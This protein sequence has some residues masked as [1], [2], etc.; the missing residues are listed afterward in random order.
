VGAFVK[1]VSFFCLFFVSG[2]ML[3]ASSHIGNVKGYT[4]NNAGELIHFSNMVFDAGKVVA[5]GAEELRQKY[6]NATFID[7]EN[8]VLLPGLIDAHG[9]VMGLGETLLQV[10][11]RESKSALDAAKMVQAYA[12][13]QQDLPWV[14]GRGWNQ[15]L[16]PGKAYPTASLLDE[17]VNNK[18]VMLSRV[19]GHASWVNTKALEIAGITKDTLDPPGGKIVRDEQGNP[20]GV[21]IDNAESLMLKHL[22]KT[23]EATLTAQLNAAG[24]HLLSEGITSVHDAGIGKVVYNYYKKRVAEHSLPVRIYPMIAATSADLRQLLETGHVQDQYDWLSIRSVKAYGDGAL[25]SRGAALLQP[26]S[27]A[28]DNTGLLVTREQDLKPLFDLVLGQGFQLN[29][30]AIGDRANRL[31]LDQ[32]GDSFERMGG[33]SLRNRV[34]H[35]QVV[36]VD[37]IPRFKALNIIPAMQPTHATSDM[38]MAKDRVGAAR[39]KGAY[40][41]Q[42]F[43]EQGSPVAF[44]SDFPVELSN[45]FFGLHAAV[46]RQD[47]NNSP[48]S[49]WIPS[50]AVTLKQAFRGFTLDAAYA[51]HQEKILGGLTQGKWADFILIDQDVFT[52]SPQNI[53]KTQVLETWIAGEKRYTKAP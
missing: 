3:A 19:D 7:G 1:I 18:P 43:L 32:F 42:T 39:L 5:I 27:D 17:Y 10:D 25:G 13:T 53:W 34:E 28:Q 36:N 14:T 33:K 46:T 31:A 52:T 29:F 44:G 50:E 15:V 51:A 24:E 30:H 12:K 16:W 48:D 4:L 41:W 21:L 11:L 38:N 37:D 23:S 2:S 47:R 22:P 9:H 20:T 26:Y 40:A 49:G 8:K 6:P 35:A 45:P